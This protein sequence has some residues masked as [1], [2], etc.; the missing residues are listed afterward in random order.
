MGE[1]A[2]NLDGW[3]AEAVGSIIGGIFTVSATLLAIRLTRRADRAT[4]LEEAGLRS[5]EGIY[6]ALV[7]FVS[8]VDEVRRGEP[9]E[10]RS[11]LTS[12]LQEC[13]M[14]ILSLLPGVRDRE[15]S[16]FVLDALSLLN[17]N[18]EELNRRLA[19][20]PVDEKVVAELI[21]LLHEWT[22]EFF[23]ALADWRRSLKWGRKAAG[24]L[25]AKAQARLDE[26]KTR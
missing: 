21:D 3:A 22:G 4:L 12:L 25:L 9:E 23:I 10:R 26:V 1:I 6:Q 5:V 13:G 20:D 15:L 19:R 14:N 17:K 8:H 24:E 11:T 18:A 16:D 2:R 7:T